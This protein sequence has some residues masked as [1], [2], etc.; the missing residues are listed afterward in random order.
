MCVWFVCVFSGIPSVCKQVVS[1]ETTR[2]IEW[3]TYTC[4]LGFQVFGKWRLLPSPSSGVCA[5]NVHSTDVSA[6][7]CSSGLWP[8]GS[9]GTDI[10]AVCRTNDKSLLVTGDDFGKVH[11][12]SYPCSQFRVRYCTL[13]CIIHIS[14]MLR[15]TLSFCKRMSEFVFSFQ[16]PSHVYGGH[17]SHVTNVTF[18]HDDSYLVSTGG[19]DMSVMQWRIVW[20]GRQR[21]IL[22]V[23]YCCWGQK[24][25]WG[26]LNWTELNWTAL[27]WT[28][29]NFN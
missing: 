14:V 7:L 8:D 29:P 24:P 2:D 15:K 21:Q 28:E 1:V 6:A 4:T 12:F 5:F 22:S 10:N 9:D 20:A 11:L 16:A 13:T 3:A 23:S 18:L 25:S 17:S 19:K 27:N 26:E